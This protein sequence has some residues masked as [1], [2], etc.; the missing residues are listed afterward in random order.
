LYE[1]YDLDMTA[2][3]KSLDPVNNF[4]QVFQCREGSGKSGSFFFFSHDK[5][6]IIKT[7]TSAE[8]STFQRI[9]KDYI[10]HLKENPST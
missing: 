1:L 6:F 2:V 10:K 4:R 8:L 7:M 9:Q 5:R 3:E